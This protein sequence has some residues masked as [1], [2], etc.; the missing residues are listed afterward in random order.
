MYRLL[1]VSLLFN[2]I[3]VRAQ[4]IDQT[5]EVLATN[6]RWDQKLL[7]A[8][9]RLKIK[10]LYSQ[11]SRDLGEQFQKAVDCEKTL[12]SCLESLNANYD[13]FDS[14][15]MYQLQWTL[16]TYVAIRDQIKV[17][18][19]PDLRRLK[20]DAEQREKI[21]RRQENAADRLR[22]LS[23]AMT[24][25]LVEHYAEN[26]L[27]QIQSELGR[28]SLWLVE[29]DDYRGERWFLWTG[30]C[31][32]YLDCKA[33]VAEYKF[34]KNLS[35]WY[36]PSKEYRESR[37]AHI[38]AAI[39]VA[40]ALGRDMLFLSAKPAPASETAAIQR[41]ENLPFCESLKS[42]GKPE[43][44][45]VLELPPSSGNVRIRSLDPYENQEGEMPNP[46]PKERTSRRSQ[47]AQGSP[48]GCFAQGTPI[49]VLDLLRGKVL[50][51]YI[52]QVVPGDRVLSQIGEGE[53]TQV[54]WD[55]VTH[56]YE[57]LLNPK[58][59][60]I[61]R[62]KSLSEDKKSQYVFNATPRHPF[63]VQTEAGKME[64][65]RAEELK[66]SDRLQSLSASLAKRSGGSAIKSRTPT[67]LESPIWSYG[68]E[69]P[70]FVYN[71]TTQQTHKYFIGQFE[72]AVL[73]HNLK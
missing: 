66:V 73:S 42:S 64:W 14:R 2:A 33:T 41:L 1:V 36:N 23:E 12:D 37:V 31:A 70:N 40:E 51:T 58:T 43:E 39:F 62:I 3:L 30:S 53:N 6:I 44:D 68:L 5:I 54:C 38:E 18:G 9:V 72:N 24:S 60:E 32:G 15:A 19:L 20:F 16:A 69:S 47:P 13:R 50:E 61:Y 65:K 8:S 25:Y 29:K 63:F 67:H 17:R 59:E 7:P 46:F 21:T 71:L 22:Y 56:T 45:S 35:W 48:G 27:D 28:Y 55:K 10:E 26:I 11:A 52:D 34:Q 49:L 4:T 57:R